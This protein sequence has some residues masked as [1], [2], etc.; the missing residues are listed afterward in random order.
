[1]KRGWS[2]LLLI[3]IAVPCLVAQS[4]PEGHHH[5]AP[6]LNEPVNSE[7]PEKLIA[8]KRE[9]EFN[10]HLAG[11]FVAVGG[12]FILLEAVL[13]KRWRLAKYIWPAS[14]LA[15]GI[16][17]LVWSDTEL[18]PFGD[19]QWLEALQHNPE[20]LQHKTFAVLLLGLGSIEWL[21]VNQTL[22]A[23]WTRLAFPVLAIAGS[24]LLLFHQHEGGMQGPDHMN[25]MA[26]IQFQHLSYAVTGIGIGVAKGAAELRMRGRKIFARLW[27]TLMVMLGILLMFYRE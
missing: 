13:G 2:P 27:P 7:T 12:A 10:H 24:I 4:V 20:V 23:A 16:F 26:R 11:L 14:F 21:Y 25:V 6:A 18:W 5:E 1:V 22:K 8:D 3:F 17:V 9:S 19:R 15:S